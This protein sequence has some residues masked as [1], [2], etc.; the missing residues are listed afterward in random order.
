MGRSSKEHIREYQREYM[1]RYK[2]SDKYQQWRIISLARRR[3]SGVDR[4]RV[5]RK[6]REILSLLGGKCVKCGQEDWRVLHIDHINGGGLAERRSITPF[7]PS[8]FH[9]VIIDSV[10]RGEKKYQILCANCNI[11]KAWENSEW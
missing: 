8:S 1:R 11:I 4:E 5:R 6:R 9:K 10:G 7:S 3:E 2:L